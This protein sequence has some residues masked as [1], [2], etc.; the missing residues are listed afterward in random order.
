MGIFREVLGQ[1]KEQIAQQE[2]DLRVS[3]VENQAVQTVAQLRAA[4]A[5]LEAG[6]QAAIRAEGV[7]FTQLLNIQREINRAENDL[8]DA[9]C[10]QAVLFGSDAQEQ[11]ED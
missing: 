3:R 2:L 4:L 1:T 9:A 7:T 10:L 8:V 11:V 6:L 5:N